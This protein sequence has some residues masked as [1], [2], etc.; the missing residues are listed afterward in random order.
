M[1]K[2]SLILISSLMAA[3]NLSIGTIDTENNTVQI[4]INNDE[5]IYGFQ[6]DING[7]ELTADGA[8]GGAAETNGFEV[9]SA[10]NT[11]LGFDISVVEDPSGE[12][13]LTSIPASTGEVLLTTLAGTITG[14]IDD[15]CLPLIENVGPQE[16]TPIFVSDEASEIEDIS[17]SNSCNLSIDKNLIFNL[18]ETYPNPFNPEL[19]INVNIEQNSQVNILVYNLNGQLVKNIYKGMLYANQTNHFK[20]NAS[21]VSSGIYII[22]IN[23]NNFTQ[24]KIVNLLK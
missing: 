23:A 18:F 4:M 24:S 22:K 10:G 16:D 2:L 3:V 7:I 1:K 12:A 11:V 9:Y 8:S 13:I 14:D 21:N 17:V 15:V 20:W 5:P 6:F 19:N